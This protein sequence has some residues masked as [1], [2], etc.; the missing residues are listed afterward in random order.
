MFTKKSHPDVLSKPPV[1][2]PDPQR[3]GCVWF[4]SAL[5]HTQETTLRIYLYCFKKMH[6]NPLAFSIWSQ[7]L[8]GQCW[9]KLHVKFL[10]SKRCLS[11]KVQITPEKCICIKSK[12]THNEEWYFPRLKKLNGH[13]AT[14]AFI[15]K[16][17]MNFTK[18]HIK[19]IWMNINEWK[20]NNAQLITF[21]NFNFI[22][23]F[24][25]FLS[26]K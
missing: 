7:L 14:Q 13:Y 23:L 8:C 10:N 17:I 5:N 20:N 4:V 19:M 6:G 24:G 1:R 18:L 12:S 16:H 26:K 21:Q 2:L 15:M 22:Y 3:L 9:K 25:T 11:K